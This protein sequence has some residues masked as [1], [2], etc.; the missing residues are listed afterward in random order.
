MKIFFQSNCFDK[1]EKEGKPQE[2]G[3]ARQQAGGEQL[4]GGPEVIPL[5]KIRYFH[6]NSMSFSISISSEML[7]GDS[8]SSDGGGGGGEGGVVELE[9]EEVQ[10]EIL[11]VKGAVEK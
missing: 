9:E 1:L 2:E 5:F 7:P 8:S 11:K 4:P 3:F 10:L 6:V